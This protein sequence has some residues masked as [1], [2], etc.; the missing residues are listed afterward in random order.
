MEI[1][2]EPD[3][4]SAE[5]AAAYLRS[6]S[7]ILRCVRSCSASMEEGSL[8]CDV[9]VSL[10]R[11][12]ASEMGTRAEVKNVNKIKHVQRAIGAC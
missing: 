9:N 1:V 4:S 10:R 7:A 11:R 3:L 6:L 12:G 5:E 2:S 8:R